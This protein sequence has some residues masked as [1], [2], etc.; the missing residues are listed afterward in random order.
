MLNTSA[1][2]WLE[3]SFD[4]QAEVDVPGCPSSKEARAIQQHWSYGRSLSQGSECRVHCPVENV[5]K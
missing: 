4:A 2:P 3:L 1:R 5:V